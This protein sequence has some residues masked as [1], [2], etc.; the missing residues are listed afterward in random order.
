[1]IED[2]VI[3]ALG[4]KGALRSALISFRKFGPVKAPF[5]VIRMDKG[6]PTS[7]LF[8]W[9]EGYYFPYE[10]ADLS[11]PA[12]RPSPTSEIYR[13]VLEERAKGSRLKAVHVRRPYGADLVAINRTSMPVFFSRTGLM[14]PSSGRLTISDYAFPDEIWNDEF[15]FSAIDEDKILLNDGL[16]TL[17]KEESFEFL[18]EF[19]KRPR[20]GSGLKAVQSVPAP[21]FASGD[22]IKSLSEFQALPYGSVFE[23]SDYDSGETRRYW[24]G[25]KGWAYVTSNRPED[26]RAKDAML[27]PE[28][29]AEL[30]GKPRIKFFFV[31]PKLMSL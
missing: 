11:L 16:R 30:F 25:Q 9:L 3:G 4:A 26:E 17:T 7:E 6:Q 31:A 27:S 18:A 23:I 28:R 21:K 24:L 5:I 13:R 8:E 15:I 2:L 19:G 1:V 14:V 22:L 12:S 10:I 29:L 20:R